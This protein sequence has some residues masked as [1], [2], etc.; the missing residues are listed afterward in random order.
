MKKISLQTWKNKELTSTIVKIHQMYLLVQL[1]KVI[2]L[3]CKEIFMKVWRLQRAFTVCM[4]NH[5]NTFPIAS[6]SAF[7]IQLPTTEDG[8]VLEPSII[9]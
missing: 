6:T 4:E 5:A 2:T 1:Q 7:V 8:E 9:R 3:D